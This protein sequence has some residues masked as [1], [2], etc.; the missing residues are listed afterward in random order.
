MLRTKEKPGRSRVGIPA[1]ARVSDQPGNRASGLVACRERP[2][3][4]RAQRGLGG[5]GRRLLGRCRL[6]SSFLGCWFG[7]RLG[8]GRLG[9]NLLGRSRLLHG[10]SF[11]GWCG[12]LFHGDLLGGCCS[13]L[14]SD[15]LDGD[16]LGR[17]S[18]LLGRRRLL[19][20][21]SLLGGCS[22]LHSDLLGR[23]GFFRCHFFCSCHTYLLDQVAKSTALPCAA[24]GLITRRPLGSGRGVMNGV[25]RGLMCGLVQCS[26]CGL[27]QSQDRAPPDWYSMTRVSKK[28]RSFFRSI[29]SLIHGKGLSSLWK[30]SSRPICVA[31]RLAM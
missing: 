22:F 19:H 17:H 28:L 5:R 6:G 20:G 18:S 2:G 23:R 7:S 26:V 25:G 13:F 4:L 11:L 12:C 10:H 21:H 27:D 16:L 24:Q 30:C 3:C 29:I 9:G 8:R 31:R 1:R 14:H 15:L